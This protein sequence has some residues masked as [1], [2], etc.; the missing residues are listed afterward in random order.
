MYQETIERGICRPSGT[1]V[2]R[3]MTFDPAEV[4]PDA[5]ACPDWPFLVGTMRYEGPR[6]RYGAEA[7]LEAVAAFL[8]RGEGRLT[9]PT[10]TEREAVI[11]GTFKRSGGHW[12]AIGL[13]NLSPLGR[14]VEGEAEL[15]V[16]ACHLRGYLR[17]LDA[18]EAQAAEVKERR[19]LAQARHTLESY[20]PEVAGELAEFKELANAAAR[21]EQRVTDEIAY[22]RRHALREHVTVIHS[23]AASAA[24][25]LGVEPPPA[26]LFV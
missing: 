18:L 20:D 15:I 5:L 24:S 16:E 7:R 25:R 13:H 1:V 14:M 11:A 2:D 10:G 4:W 8:N 17:K 9:A 3:T 26:P 21:H 6:G 23:A 12:A 22:R 19:E